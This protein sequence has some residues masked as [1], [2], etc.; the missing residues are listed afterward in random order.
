MRIFIGDQNLDELQKTFSPYL[1]HQAYHSAC[2]KFVVYEGLL[3]RMKKESVIYQQ[4]D[5]HAPVRSFLASMFGQPAPN[6]RRSSSL[7]RKPLLF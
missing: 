4:T 6:L 5:N 7:Q 1:T 2:G 3:I